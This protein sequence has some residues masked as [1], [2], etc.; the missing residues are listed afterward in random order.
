MSNT[1]ALIRAVR[2]PIVLIALGI[3]FAV[4]LHG[5]YSFTRT[6]PA[7]LII[8][9]GLWLLERMVPYDDEHRYDGGAA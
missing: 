6:W 8:Y 1:K 5:S 4:D 7:L 9:G 2:G 3:L